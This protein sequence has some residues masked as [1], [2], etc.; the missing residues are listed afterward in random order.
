VGRF[1]DGKRIEFPSHDVHC[2]NY[3]RWVEREKKSVT[4]LPGGNKLTM[5]VGKVAK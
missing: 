3:G 5:V 1:V 4:S 2:L